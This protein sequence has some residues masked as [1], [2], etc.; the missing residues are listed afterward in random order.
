MS[1]SE[2]L[3]AF[4][5]VLLMKIREESAK[6]G[7]RIVSHVLMDNILPVIVNKKCNDTD[8]V[9]ISGDRINVRF[10]DIMVSFIY[11]GAVPAINSEQMNLTVIEV[12]EQLYAMPVCLRT[13]VTINGGQ[14]LWSELT[15]TDVIDCL[16]NMRVATQSFTKRVEAAQ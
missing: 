12:L 6:N 13:E 15:G 14:K 3:E 10:H 8:C 16:F 1:A 5:M 4:G 2:K 11:P 7:L 9:A